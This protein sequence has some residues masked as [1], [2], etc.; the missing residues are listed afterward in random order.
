MIV[1]AL[2]WVSSENNANKVEGDGYIILNAKKMI[3]DSIIGTISSIIASSFMYPEGTVIVGL[4]QRS[5]NK[6]KCSMRL[7]GKNS[8]VNIHELLARVCPPIGID[9]GGHPRAGGC[10]FQEEKEQEFIG[11]VEKE[12]NIRRISVKI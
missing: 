8:D 1:H 9:Y 7:C 10:L 4:A 11:A 12:L 5:D 6:I 3:D 2:K